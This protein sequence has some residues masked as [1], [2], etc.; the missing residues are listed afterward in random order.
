MIIKII[1]KIVYFFKI[2]HGLVTGTSKTNLK[3]F[4]QLNIFINNNLATT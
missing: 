3:T 4:T 2:D 1:D